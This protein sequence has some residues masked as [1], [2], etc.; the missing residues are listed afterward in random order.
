MGY[1]KAIICAV[2]LLGVAACSTAK[3]VEVQASTSCFDQAVAFSSGFISS[4]EAIREDKL[5]EAFNLIEG[6]AET[7]QE[8]ESLEALSEILF[9]PV[10]QLHA[11][12]ESSMSA[13]V[14]DYRVAGEEASC[15]DVFDDNERDKILDMYSELWEQA[16]AA[17]GE[18]AEG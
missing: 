12:I 14:E 10:N 11:A 6:S 5:F 16:L 15:E 1:Q 17:L 9:T 2:V 18:S 13:M 7:E 4:A 8:A 3:H